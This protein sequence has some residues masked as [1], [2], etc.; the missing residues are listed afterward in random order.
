MVNLKLPCSSDSPESTALSSFQCCCEQR[1]DSHQSRSLNFGPRMD[2]WEMR[3]AS[4]LKIQ[5]GVPANQ[6]NPRQQ[7]VLDA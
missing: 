3:L 4:P 5:P 1:G 2:S 7:E 6:M